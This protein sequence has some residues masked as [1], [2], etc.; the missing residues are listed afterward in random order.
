MLNI[1]KIFLSTIFIFILSGC[2]NKQIEKQD[3]KTNEPTIKEEPKEIKT[4]KLIKPKKVYNTYKYCSKHR[5]DMLFAKNYIL[6]E[7]NKAYFDK[8]DILGAKAQLFLVES[9]SPTVF[10]KNIN[11]AI[12]VYD[13]NFEKAKKNSCSLKAFKIHPISTIKKNIEE[14]KK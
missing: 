5:K 6:N 1:L 3:L 11:A 8:K 7:F 10:A 4:Q 2:V 9:N 14:G 13:E 12:K